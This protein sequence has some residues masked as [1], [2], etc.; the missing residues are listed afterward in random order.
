LTYRIA[1]LPPALALAEQ[2]ERGLKVESPFVQPSA[3][4]RV[5]KILGLKIP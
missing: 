3:G 5:M 2:A 1:F 4:A